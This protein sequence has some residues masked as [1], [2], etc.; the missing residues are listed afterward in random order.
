MGKHQGAPTLSPT[1]HLVLPSGMATTSPMASCPGT[2]GL[3][4]DPSANIASCCC[5][6]TLMHDPQKKQNKSEGMGEREGGGG[7]GD[8]KT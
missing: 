2:T 6:F 8:E 7:G 5:L 1:F 4:L 3:F